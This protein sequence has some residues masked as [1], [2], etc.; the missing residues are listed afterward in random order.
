MKRIFIFLLVLAAV[1]ISQ[2]VIV[3]FDDPNLRI[4]VMN[5]LSLNPNDYNLPTDVNMLKLTYLDANHHGISN[6]NGLNYATNLTALYLQDNNITNLTP[7]SGLKKMQYL[8]LWDNNDVNNLAPL[9]DMNNLL[10]FWAHHCKIKDINVVSKFTKLQSLHLG[11]NLVSDVNAIRGLTPLLYLNLSHNHVTDINSLEN[12][13]NLIYLYLSYNNIPDINAVSGMNKLVEVGLTDVN[14]IDISPLADVNKIKYV[15]L[16][17]NKIT[18][19]Y[20]LTKDVNFITLN[21]S[22]NRMD[23]QSWCVYLRQIKKNNPTASIYTS[24]ATGDFINTDSTDVN[25]LRIFAEKWLSTPCNTNNA[26]CNCADSTESG[27][28]NF[29][30][31]VDFADV[32]MEQL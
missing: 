10:S 28:V 3:S 19:I 24:P 11:Y 23:F 8:S 12:L 1:D 5:K 14:L 17:Y 27:R 30:D 16:G 21:L 25:D 31:F 2:A 18:D 26:Y 22:F 13:T 32:W 7:L 15:W 9:A 29:D 20:A 6:L 4:A